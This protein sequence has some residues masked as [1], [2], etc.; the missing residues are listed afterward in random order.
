MNNYWEQRYITGGR[1]WGDSPSVSVFE[2][3]KIYSENNIRHIHIPGC[4]YGR[5]AGYFISKGYD[6]SG[7]KIS[8]TACKLA[9]E[10]YPSLNI[11]NCSV[12]SDDIEPASADAVYAFN[13]LHLFKSNE[14]SRLIDLWSNMIKTDGL[15]FCTVFSELEDSFGKGIQTEENT[16]ESKP[17]RPVHYFAENDLIT[18]FRNLT[19]IDEGIFD[20][21]EEH[22]GRHIHK[23][24]YIILKKEK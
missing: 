17:G 13:I 6:V 10:K 15:I 2:A 7:C 18:H 4:G 8:E 9:E 21:P 22:E 23:L 12:L 16:F 24:R 20:E 5:N 3:E 14:R 1:I 11:R 19:L